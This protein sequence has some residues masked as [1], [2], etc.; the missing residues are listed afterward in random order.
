MHKRNL[1]LRDRTTDGFHWPVP[2]QAATPCQN[3]NVV[4]CCLPNKWWFILL[5]LTN[6][7]RFNKE[8]GLPSSTCWQISFWAPDP[9]QTGERSDEIPTW[10]VNPSQQIRSTV[11]NRW[12]WRIKHN[13]LVV[14]NPLKN[15]SHLGWLFPIYGK[16]KNVP[17]HQPEFDA[18]KIFPYISTC[19]C[20]GFS[21]GC[22]SNRS[23]GWSKLSSGAAWPSSQLAMDSRWAM[24]AM[25]TRY[26]YE[27]Q[28][29]TLVSPY[30]TILHH[31]EYNKYR[32][33]SIYF[34][35][36]FWMKQE[37]QLQPT[38]V[39]SGPVTPVKTPPEIARIRWSQTP[40]ALQ[41][42]PLAVT[43]TGSSFS[44]RSLHLLYGYSVDKKYV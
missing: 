20:L 36:M 37:T 32:R 29:K 16:I 5:H 7:S 12:R 40:L 13:W 22:S 9:S 8:Q 10:D 18:P 2:T 28:K 19:N 30:F 44:A 23:F 41:N 39:L 3:L 15:I 35:A 38:M 11:S 26:L 27:K 1:S 4:P 43:N 31:V 25:G 24:D 34:I 17:N 42:S 21:R 14:W 33:W 6:T